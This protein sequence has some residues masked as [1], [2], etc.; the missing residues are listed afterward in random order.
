MNQNSK[1]QTGQPPT[2]RL[3]K[4]SA[5]TIYCKICERT[6]KPE[7]YNCPEDL[8]CPLLQ[9]EVVGEETPEKRQPS[10]KKGSQ[11]PSDT[12]QHTQR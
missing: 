11:A 7:E 3:A 5:M 8:M 9:F 4:P 1:K 6:F 2:G 12:P 10:D